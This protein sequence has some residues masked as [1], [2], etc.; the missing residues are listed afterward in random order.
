[1]DK[2]QFKKNLTDLLAQRID[3]QVLSLTETLKEL[4]ELA[5]SPL[6]Q[7]GEQMEAASGREVYQ[8]DLEAYTKQLDDALLN[9]KIIKNLNILEINS[10]VK[11]GSVVVSDDKT[12]FISVGLGQISLDGKTVFAISLKSPIFQAFGNKTV[13]EKFVFRDLQSQIVDIY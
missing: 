3:E 11:A 5:N 12:F 1:M 7:A 13:G 2:L 10:T 8:A 9:Q 6:E 4:K